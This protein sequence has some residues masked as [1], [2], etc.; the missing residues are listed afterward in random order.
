MGSNNLS[1]GGLK[2]GGGRFQGRK[3]L[4]IG[5]AK[6]Q[7]EI[8][9]RTPNHLKGPTSLGGATGEGRDNPRN[10]LK[11]K[12]WPRKFEPLNDRKKVGVTDFLAIQSLEGRPNPPTTNPPPPKGSGG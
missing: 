8:T 10:F 1:T 11:T 6:N 12:H 4:A 7:I 9:K 2:K 5:E 3:H